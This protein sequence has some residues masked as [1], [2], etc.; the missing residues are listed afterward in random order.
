MDGALV[1]C[2]GHAARIV[3]DRLADDS[4]RQCCHH[5]GAKP[6][7]VGDASA[8]FDGEAIG[9]RYV[10]TGCDPPRGRFGP[11][12]RHCN[13]QPDSCQPGCRR[14]IGSA[15]AYRPGR[16]PETEGIEFVQCPPEWA[17]TIEVGGTLLPLVL[18]RFPG[19]C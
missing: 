11:N 10:V 5:A 4:L 13:A 1:P 6:G 19:L 7:R 8:D 9:H 12:N 15:R 3:L 14:R 17:M 18:L 16:P 2:V